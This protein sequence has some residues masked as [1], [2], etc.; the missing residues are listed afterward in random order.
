MVSNDL[1]GQRPAVAAFRDWLLA[2]A[3][4]SAKS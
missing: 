3:A 4:Q 1:G 2:E